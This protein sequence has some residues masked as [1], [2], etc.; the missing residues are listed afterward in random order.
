LL[1]DDDRGLH[2]DVQSEA[3][4]VEKVQLSQLA[5]VFLSLGGSGWIEMVLRKE[6]LQLQGFIF[7]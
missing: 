1:S 4:G 7:T 2:E 6:Q 5:I 3:V